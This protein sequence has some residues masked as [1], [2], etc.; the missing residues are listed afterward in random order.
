MDMFR[1]GSLI[2]IGIAIGAIAAFQLFWEWDTQ[3]RFYK[4]A[5]AMALNY[6]KNRQHFDTLGQQFEIE[7]PYGSNSLCLTR[8]CERDHTYSG[9]SR[10]IEQKLVFQKTFY[11][12]LIKVLQLPQGAFL[13]TGR[14]GS[15]STI[16]ISYIEDG[17]IVNAT[18]HYTGRETSDLPTCESAPAPTSSGACQMP[19]SDTWHMKYEWLPESAWGTP[20]AAAARNLP[21]IPDAPSFEE[22]SREIM[23]KNSPDTIKCPLEPYTEYR[24]CMLKKSQAQQTR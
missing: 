4:F 7:A 16:P 23:M 17:L 3:H 11:P 22:Y 19:L 18:L 1:L 6:A 9:S 10:T 21:V 14:D 8:K 20:A 13:Y 15:V 12:H 5:D 24:A 2:F